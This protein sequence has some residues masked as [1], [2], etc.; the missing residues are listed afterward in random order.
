MPW[1][2][3]CSVESPRRALAEVRRV[4]KPGGRFL[5]LEHVAAA[6]GSR[7]ASVQRWVAP[8]VRLLAHGCH[9]D[10]DTLADIRAAGFSG[11]QADEF[12]MDSPAVV[13]FWRP[14][15]CGVAIK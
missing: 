10:R 9:V 2:V 12:Y 4:L 8:A 6:P 14:H 1:Q 15:V 5:F 7:L 3:L 13:A 11:V